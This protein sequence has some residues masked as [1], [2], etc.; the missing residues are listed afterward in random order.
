MQP[1]APSGRGWRKLIGVG[2][3]GATI[4]VGAGI[5]SASGGGGVASPDPPALDRVV[6]VESCA[7][8]RI[9]A[10]GSRVRLEGQDLGETTSVLFAGKVGRIAVE[11]GSVGELAVE[12][13]VPEG[14]VTGTV[15]VDAYGSESETP[16]DEPL[17]IV[18][19]SQIPDVGE[20]KL[21]SAEATPRKTYFDGIR[22]PR[23]SYLF[24]GKQATDIRVEVI[25][26][27]TR[28]VVRSWV[29]P[30]AE[31]SALNRASWNGR[32]ATGAIA[33]NGDYRFRIGAV[34]GG[35]AETTVDARFRFHRFRFPVRGR[36]DFGDGYGAG[37][38]HQGQ[39]VFAKCG[40][41]LVAARGGRVQFNKTHSAAGNYLVIDGRGT[42]TDHM[43]AHLRERS[44]LRAGARVRTGQRIGVV[45]DSGNASGCHLHF[46]AWS[47]PGWYEGGEALASVAKMLRAW[48]AWS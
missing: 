6:C 18:G 20:F 8:E 30:G 10:E 43:Y 46:E 12:A 40:T 47:A 14:A 42:G 34:A 16:A 48:D 44:P 5:A 23:V 26:R 19:V 38:N 32:T 21:T 33:P 39:D 31:P 3:A 37:R 29:E 4:C 13:E 7:G 25:D 11:P 17:K 27:R 1:A 36:H 24:Q 22:R 15:K 41:P 2:V 35:A 28:E 45:G 9:A